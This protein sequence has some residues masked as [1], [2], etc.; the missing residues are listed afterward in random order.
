MP[1]ALVLLICLFG[2]KG[3]LKWSYSTSI[4][5]PFRLKPMTDI[6]K[7][8]Q[9]SLFELDKESCFIILL[10]LVMLTYLEEPLNRARFFNYNKKLE[11]Y[12]DSKDINRFTRVKELAHIIAN[13]LKLAKVQGFERF[14]Q[15]LVEKNLVIREREGPV[16]GMAWKGFG[17]VHSHYSISELGKAFLVLQTALRCKSINIGTV[18]ITSDWDEVLEAQIALIV[19]AFVQKRLVLEKLPDIFSTRRPATSFITQLI[20][21]FVAGASKAVTHEQIR[22]FIW[23][24]A[25]EIHI[26]EI[27]EALERLQPLLTLSKTTVS[28]NSKGRKV[29]AGYA[30]FIIEV[31]IAVDD[32]EIVQSLYSADNF[33]K[34]SQEILKQFSLWL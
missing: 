21:E 28:L 27:P 26:G 15:L 19:Q 4:F 11:L 29:R 2:E 23:D 13:Q 14:L 17:G 32:M 33:S 12:F 7:I 8:V 22:K 3:S 31:A 9:E 1:F 16:E 10:T 34:S 25:G 24:K 30:T 18:Q 5:I 20:F 6:R